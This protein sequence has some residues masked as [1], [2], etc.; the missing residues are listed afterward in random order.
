ME[1][2]RDYGLGFG[3]GETPA[4]RT[5]GHGGGFAG[6]S[7]NLEI[8]RDTGYVAVVLANQDGASRPVEARLRS[9]IGRLQAD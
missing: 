7:S 4:G 3:L 2:S 8:Y 1:G 9:L 6:I 5:A